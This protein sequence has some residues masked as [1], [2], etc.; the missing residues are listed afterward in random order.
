M[1]QSNQDNGARAVSQA[2]QR[3]STA[4][5]RRLSHIILGVHP[6]NTIF[7]FNWHN[8]R[9][10][11]AFYGRASEDSIGHD[12]TIADIGGGRS[13]YFYRFAHL[14]GDYIVV[15]L[16]DSLPEGEA[17]PIRQLG[18][19]AEHIPLADSS[20]DV[21][22][23]NQVLEHVIDPVRATAEIYRIL[24]PGGRFFGSVPHVSPIHL[25]PFDF[26]RYTS[27]GVEQLLREAGFEAIAVEGNGGVFSTAALMI[28]MDVLLSKHVPGKPQRFN[29]KLAAVLF[30]AIGLL[31]LA[32]LLADALYGDKGRTPSNLCW[33]ASKR[34]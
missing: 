30:P 14:A 8:V 20:V 22:L 19:A 7:S 16:T 3:R 4:L 24:R 6:H 28:A 26:R 1:W 2:Q 29:T 27:L 5:A 18:G 25:E 15:D 12:I 23:C 33:R 9:H 21:V 31:N 11:N 17:R 10:I 13:P 32:G 34:P